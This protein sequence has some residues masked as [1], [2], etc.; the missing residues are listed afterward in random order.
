[1]LTKD[2]IYYV[3]EDG[4]SG[5]ALV[6]LH[7]NGEDSSI[8]ERF[9]REF[10]GRNKVF[11][12]TRGHGKSAKRLGKCGF[13]D[14]ADDIRT[15]LTEA[16]IEKAFL[17]GF[18]DGGNTALHFLIRY[19]EFSVGAA[20]IGANIFPGGMVFRWRA[21]VF[22]ACLFARGE[23]KALLRLMRKEPRLEF[24]SLSRINAPV[25]VMAGSR[26][27]IKASHTRNI[28][29]S[30]PGAELYTGQGGHMFIFEDGGKAAAARIMEFA[31]K[32]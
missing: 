2:G 1:M 29:R 30:V 12:D 18:S 9:S 31:S 19:P 3:I 27:M 32:Q 23:R 4:G 5:V 26:D 10:P 15:V 11:I 13:F 25:L 28:A 22:F 6:F 21:A 20:V 8:F 17:I 16:G 24:K 14:L 7:G